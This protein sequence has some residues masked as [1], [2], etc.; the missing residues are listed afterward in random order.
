MNNTTSEKHDD[1]QCVADI[2]FDA[3]YNW[4]AYRVVQAED[5]LYLMT[6]SGCSC[7]TPFEA[8]DFANFGDFLNTTGEQFVDHVTGP[9]TRYQA[10]AE[11]M[12]L[13]DCRYREWHECADEK[14]LEEAVHAILA[15]NINKTIRKETE[16]A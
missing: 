6:D 1:V 14:E 5:G 16:Q 11:L 13:M 2:T 3:C 9:L 10:V 4:D 15:T 8:V 7:Y 12:S